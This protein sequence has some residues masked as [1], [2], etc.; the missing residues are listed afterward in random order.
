MEGGN[1]LPLWRGALTRAPSRIRGQT[2]AGSARLG[3]GFPDE[4]EEHSPEE[5]NRPSGGDESPH[6]K[7][8]TAICY[9]PPNDHAPSM[10]K[11]LF[12]CRSSG[13]A[14]KK[15]N[16]R[17]AL[18]SK[19]SAARC[20]QKRAPKPL[21]GLTALRSRCFCGG[22]IS[23]NRGWPETHAT[24]GGQPRSRSAIQKGAGG[25]SDYL[26]GAWV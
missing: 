10:K 5:G 19:N 11:I 9:H 20:L 13:G 24:F 25:A 12:T 8:E 22:N 3:A 2:A 14:E 7:Q 1:N 16:L 26:V 23:A 18:F 17:R 21:L 15:S 6:P 4:N